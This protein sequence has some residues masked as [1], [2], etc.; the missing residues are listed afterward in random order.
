[1]SSQLS[2]WY[3]SMTFTYAD[4]WDDTNKKHGTVNTWD[5]WHL[6]PTS[7]PVFQQPLTK[8]NYI[9]IPGSDGSLDLTEALTGRP[10]YQNREGSF[11]F[12]VM[13]GYRS[14]WAGGHSRF[15]NWLH[16]KKL[17]CVLDDDPGYYYEG[18]FTI[19]E[20]TSNNDGT[21]SNITIGYNV[22]P[23]KYAIRKSSEDWLWDPF[24]FET[25]IINKNTKD[26]SINGSATVTIMNYRKPL[27]PTFIFTPTTSEGKFSIVTEWASV[28][29]IPEGNFK[30]PHIELTEGEN[31]INFFGNGSVTIDFR[32]GSL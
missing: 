25:D 23:Y 14:S 18:R 28:T 26:I 13:N 32:G 3:H 4:E 27:V 10:T 20:W 5:D 24:N 29:E 21:W 1:M 16:G 15:A 19:D 9:E 2:K 30:D 8:T 12:I 6:V 31:I 22:D 11:E 7:R 17:R